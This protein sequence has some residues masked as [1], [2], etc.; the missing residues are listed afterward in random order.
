M[1]QS[2]PAAAVEFSR[3]APPSRM[4]FALRLLT[5]FWGSRASL[6]AWLM[7]LVLLSVTFGG[8]YIFLW[9][10]RWQGQFFDSLQHK[11]LAAFMSLMSW[12]FVVAG[13]AIAVGAVQ[14]F[15]TN[16][17]SIKWRE[18]LTRQYL[19]R[20]MSERNYHRLEVGAQLDNPDQR[21]AEDIQL[22]TQN[23]LSVAIGL[24]VAVSTI[25]SFGVVLWQL[26]GAASFSLGGQQFYLPG[27]MVLASVAYA[28]IGSWLVVKIGG[29]IVHVVGAQQRLE[30]GFRFLL[31][32]VRRAAE[33]IAFFRG[34]AAERGRLGQSFDKVIRNWRELA[35]ARVR[36]SA[37]QSVYS[38][39]GEVLPLLL[40]MPQF[41][42]G[43]ITFGAVM[44]TRDAFTQFGASLSY[45][46][47][48]YLA[49][50][51]LQ[52]IVRRLHEL[53][54]V[55][56]KPP[57]AGITQVE[58]EALEIVIERLQ[59]DRPG[60]EPLV[61]VGS[62]TI[63]PGERWLISGRSGVGKSTLLRALAGLWRSG[64][65]RI[66]MPAKLKQMFISQRPFFP[67][68][69]LREA[70]AFP[71]PADAFETVAFE[72]VLSQ[73]A[74]AHLRARLDEQTEWDRELSVGE[75]Q[76]VAFCRIF[77]QRPALIFLDEATS[78]L[79]PE[80]ERQMYQL[81]IDGLPQ[82]TLISVAHGDSLDAF[83]THGLQLSAEQAACASLIP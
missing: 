76:R 33:Q 44:Q 52:A 47:Q 21:I 4:R 37:T 31:I 68:G 64:Q 8:V 18:W 24:L 15:F 67:V 27:Y 53:V 29:G 28:L 38:E 82:V 42:A 40:V 70:L 48:S 11:D 80:A 17:I 54:L 34:E 62:L 50:A 66:A 59:L 81:L 45:F 41:F 83:H 36:V 74:L 57:A 12:Y 61:Q 51:H 10:N 73:C 35:V 77:L 5:G 26:G 49:I 71:A 75:Q 16:L 23:I 55:M 69:T 43:Q 60:G 9:K 1:I 6:G 39:A 25:G 65:G 14:A 79:D 63:R 22:F 30:A 46:V 32:H 13:I 20:W 58:T 78:A 56:D 3:P 2:E 19:D 7:L 72:R